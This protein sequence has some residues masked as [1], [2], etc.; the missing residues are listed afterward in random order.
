MVW[1]RVRRGGSGGGETAG[2]EARESER[3]S[4]LWRTGKE[5]VVQVKDDSQKHG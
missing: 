1:G 2:E 4:V 5:V 3:S